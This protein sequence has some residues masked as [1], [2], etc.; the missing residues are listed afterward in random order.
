MKLAF[1]ANL[2]IGSHV[3]WIAVKRVLRYLKGT[4]KMGIIYKE[5]R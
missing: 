2:M 5:N 4:L 3:D 1:L